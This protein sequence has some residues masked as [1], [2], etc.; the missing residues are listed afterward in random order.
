M[1]RNRKK[2]ADLTDADE[3]LLLASILAV[4]WSV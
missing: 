3:L 4:F 1:D 2:L